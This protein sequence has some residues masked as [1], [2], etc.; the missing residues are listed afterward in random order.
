MSNVV[1]LK[2]INEPDPLDQNV[3]H[4]R[5]LQRIKEIKSDP[6]QYK[7][8]RERLKGKTTDEERA[9]VLVEFIT[10]NE[11]LLTALPDN[12]DDRIKAAWTITVT[13]VFIFA[14]PACQTAPQNPA[15]TQ[16]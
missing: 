13:T 15:P 9:E 3:A 16:E 7:E 12:E 5:M 4:A 8:L 10:D 2:T 11:D 14:T 1:A 6:T